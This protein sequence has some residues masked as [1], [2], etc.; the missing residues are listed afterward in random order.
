MVYDNATREV[1]NHGSN[2]IDTNGSL[3]LFN[4]FYLNTISERIAPVSIS[5]NAITCNY[6]TS[7]IFRISA[8]VT[9]V[10]TTNIINLPSITDSTRNYMITLIYTTNAGAFYSN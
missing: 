4:T 7:G 8:Q 10:F 5:T 2:Y 6:L 3:N 1:T 9:G